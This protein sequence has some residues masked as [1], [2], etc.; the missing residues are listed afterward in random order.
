MTFEV[1]PALIAQ[2]DRPM[3]RD[4]GRPNVEHGYYRLRVRRRWW[5]R[6]RYETRCLFCSQR[7]EDE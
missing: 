1:C 4:D 6:R 5:Q 3:F 7:W 2:P